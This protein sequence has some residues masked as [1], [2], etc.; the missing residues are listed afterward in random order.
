[1]DSFEFVKEFLGALRVQIDTINAMSAFGVGGVLAIWASKL[2]IND[3]LSMDGF[4]W[5]ELLL[6]PFVLFIGSII[7]GY[8]MSAFIA[9]YHYEIL[10][11]RAFGKII[12]V[13]PKTHFVNE[14]QVKFKV[15][16]AFHVI[17]SLAGIIGLALWFIANVAWGN[18]RRNTH[19]IT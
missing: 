18:H 13:T 16:S 7:L 8:F 2:R 3:N 9:G 5:A 6:L 19:E 14:Y 12:T 4:R 15:M 11:Q 10:T 17:L 1:M